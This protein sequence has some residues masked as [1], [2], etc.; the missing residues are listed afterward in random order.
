MTTLW[1]PPW[2][3]QGLWYFL[4]WRNWWKFTLVPK[5]GQFLASVLVTPWYLHWASISG[6]SYCEQIVT[7]SSGFMLHMPRRLIRTRT[8]ARLELPSNQHPRKARPSA[9][10][11][12]REHSDTTASRGDISW[13]RQPTVK[14]PRSGS[15][16][17]PRWRHFTSRTRRYRSWSWAPY[18]RRRPGLRESLFA[19]QDGNLGR[20]RRLYFRNK[21]I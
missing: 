7:F 8:E 15:Q 18:C 12:L 4:H 11:R 3:S 5:W 21:S 6:T 19:L 20:E 16:I 10:Q 9:S 14:P 17:S 2:Y 1:G 13:R